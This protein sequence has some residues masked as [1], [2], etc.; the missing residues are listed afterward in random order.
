MNIVFCLFITG[1]TWQGWPCSLE[2]PQR[3]RRTCPEGTMATEKAMQMQ[4]YLEWL[5][6]VWRPQTGRSVRRREREK[7]ELL[8]TSSPNSPFPCIVGAEEVRGVRDEGEKMSPGRKGW[9]EEKDVLVLF[10]TISIS[11]SIGN[12]L[13]FHQQIWPKTVTDKWHP[14]VYLDPWRTFSSWLTL[15]SH[16]LNH[17]QGWGPWKFFP[18]QKLDCTAYFRAVRSS[19]FWCQCFTMQQYPQ[20]FWWWNMM[21]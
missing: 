5:Q 12:K 2:R 13:M 14:S 15:W 21:Q 16:K 18:A 10:F 3:D 20:E 4:V 17:F 1:G 11:N 8:W 7:E 9:E 19:L 6:S